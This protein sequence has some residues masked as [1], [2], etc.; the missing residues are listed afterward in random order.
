MWFECLITD[1][2]NVADL[3]LPD[4]NVRHITVPAFIVTPQQDYGT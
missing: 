3:L 2:E 1:A 4:M